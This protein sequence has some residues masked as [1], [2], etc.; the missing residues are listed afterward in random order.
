MREVGRFVGCGGLAK[1]LAPGRGT[2]GL[3]RSAAFQGCKDRRKILKPYIS[4]GGACDLPRSAE[5]RGAQTVTGIMVERL[6][7]FWN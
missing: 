2:Y 6:G 5:N 1:S 4:T 3:V 7:E